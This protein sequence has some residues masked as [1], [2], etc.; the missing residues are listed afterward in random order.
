MNLVKKTYFYEDYVIERVNNYYIIKGVGRVS[1]KEVSYVLENVFKDYRL[2]G[3]NLFLCIENIDFFSR[4]FI[5]SSKKYK[6]VLLP[7]FLE[8]EK[9]SNNFFATPL[10]T[11]NFGDEPSPNNNGIIEI[12]N[13]DELID[14]SK[15]INLLLDFCRKYG[16][17]YYENVEEN[18]IL[19]GLTTNIPLTIHIKDFLLTAITI[20]LLTELDSLVNAK[21]DYSKNLI[22]IMSLSSNANKDDIVYR[23]NSYV[24]NLKELYTQEISSYKSYTTPITTDGKDKGTI[25]T[26]NLIQALTYY[27]LNVIELRGS[28]SICCKCGVP[29]ANLLQHLCPECYNNDYNYY[30]NTRK[31]ELNAIHRDLKD[32]L[33]SLNNNAINELLKKDS[34]NIHNPK[35]V[36]LKYL[37][38]LCKSYDLI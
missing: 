38:D 17:P 7:F 3:K 20:Y 32:K 33:I 22:K 5:K 31:K 16:I 4:I 14:N 19:E 13:Y 18:I 11:I 30:D 29:T 23:F 37:E 12:K 35:Y 34:Y 28:F 15:V 25:K 27:Y 21:N 36:D 2:L 8:N 9:R 24:K 6:V 1:Y 10:S 26:I